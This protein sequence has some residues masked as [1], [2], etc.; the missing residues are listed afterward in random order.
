MEMT[1]EQIFIEFRKMG[2]KTQRVR[3]GECIDLYIRKEDREIII[4]GALEE[5]DNLIKALTIEK[6][7]IKLTELGL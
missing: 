3:N 5:G 2:F 6:R 1:R 4:R 7:D